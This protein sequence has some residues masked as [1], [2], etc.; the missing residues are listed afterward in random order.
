[1]NVPWHQARDGDTDEFRRQR[2][3]SSRMWCV[4]SRFHECDCELYS[5]G[6]IEEVNEEYYFSVLHYE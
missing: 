2:I 3:L 4:H 6:H 5:V 1:M